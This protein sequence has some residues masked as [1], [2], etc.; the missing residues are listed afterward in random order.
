MANRVNHCFFRSAESADNLMCGNAV[1]Q[2]TD[3]EF[4]NFFRL[5][6]NNHEVFTAVDIIDNA[7]NEEGFRKQTCKR[8]EPDFHAERKE[9]AQTDQK[10]RIEK[11]LTDVQTGIFFEDQRH[12]IRAAGGSRL[13]EHDR[14]ACRCQNDGVD[15]FKERLCRQRLGNGND[16]F[17][18]H[19]KEGECKTAV[20]RADTRFFANENET[21]EEKQNIDYGDPRC[22][23]KDRKRF[24][25]NRT[26]T[27]DAARNESVWNFEK[28][29]ADSQKDDTDGHKNITCDLL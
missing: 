24:A 20:S 4:G 3:H 22:G 14:G 19:G 27:A 1:V 17:Q 12:D 9:R 26:D 11:C 5:F 29:Y 6:G 25:E 23:G 13:R 18:D 2:L 15:E 7:V 21:D 10:I 8:E 28:V 16:L